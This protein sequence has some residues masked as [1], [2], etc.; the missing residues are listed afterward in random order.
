[1]AAITAVVLIS[2]T[3]A[4]TTAASGLSYFWYSVADAAM[5][6]SSADVITDVV[7]T[8]VTAAV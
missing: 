4:A 6:A 5:A 1:M 7:T 3:L 2:L 8:A